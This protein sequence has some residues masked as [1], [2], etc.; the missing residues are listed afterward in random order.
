MLAPWKESYDKARQC[1]KK[2]TYHFVDKGPYR[3]SFGFSSRHVQIWELDLTEGGEPKN[4]CFRV[5]LEKILQSPLDCKEVKPTTPKENQPWIFP[6]KTDAEA[7][8]PIFWLPD[9]KSGLTGKDLDAGKDWRQREKVV[10]EDEMARR[11][12]DSMDMNFSKLQEIA[13]NREAWFP[14]VHG[15]AKSQTQ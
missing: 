13:K 4:W 11:I 3:K 9:V 14:G 2:Q 5:V 6:G 7:E 1:I 15:V 12:T 8:A 10:T